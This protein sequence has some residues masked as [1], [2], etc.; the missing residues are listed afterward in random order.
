MTGAAG[1]L[2]FWSAAWVIA[3]R[4]FLAILTSRA[5]LFFLLGPLFPLIV[6][7][8]AGSI[9]QSIDRGGGATA[10]IAVAME[11]SD[12]DRVIAAR[13][14]FASSL[15]DFAPPLRK[16]GA[17][18]A[19]MAPSEFMDAH[20]SEFSGVL[21][22]SLQSPGLAGSPALLENSK[23]PLTM[24]CSWAAAASVPKLPELALTPTAAP[25]TA[26]RPRDRLVTAQAA[27]TLLFLL[28]M[29]LAGMVLSNLVEEKG[30]KIIEILAA[31]IPMDALFL[32]KLF[33]MLGISTVGIAIWGSCAALILMLGG[34]ALG[35]ITAPAVGWTAFFALGTIYFA[36]GY[37]LLGSIFLAIG[38]LAT[39]VREVQTL[40]MPVTMFQ[41][42][43]F[44]F[45]SLAIAHQGDILEWIAIAFPLSSP[46]AMI[47]RAA[48]QPELWPHALALCWQ[49]ACVALFIRLGA[50]LFRRKVMQ[51]GTPQ[52]KA[53]NAGRRRLWTLLRKGSESRG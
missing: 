27:Q 18:P 32:G 22:G 40:S 50:R 4:D 34:S 51:S 15:N 41:V 8:L 14:Q 30:N 36:M 1:R 26:Q 12:A 29:L 16:V 39:T 11:Q 47:A 23:G 44:F 24:L 45:A 13:E 48:T 21:Y 49:I 52:G 35:A 3:R 53:G 7:V 20:G 10:P 31:A 33:A 28:I 38:S 6:G 5:F 2:S 46:F 43:V 19:G 17:L 37:L 42:L 9:G 25:D